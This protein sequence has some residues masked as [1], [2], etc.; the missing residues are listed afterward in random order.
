M[1]TAICLVIT[2]I[3]L[4]ANCARADYVE[5]SD[6]QI[7]QAA[8]EPAKVEAMAKDATVLEGAILI[9]DVVVKIVDTAL[10]PV[11][12]DKRIGSVVACVFRIMVTRSKELSVALARAIAASPGASATPDVVSVIQQAVMKAAGADAGKA[13]GNSYILAMQTVAG[14]PGGGKSVPPLPPPPPVAIP[15]EGQSLP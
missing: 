13:F 1:K 4:T 8:A 6:E 12:R 3:T 11:T 15:Y 5:P 2:A 9:K 14:A 7:E 10:P